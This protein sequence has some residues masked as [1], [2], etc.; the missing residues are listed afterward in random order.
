[1]DKVATLLKENLV[2]MK[3]GQ[4]AKIAEYCADDVR[5]T[6]ECWQLMTLTLENMSAPMLEEDLF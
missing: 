6:R 2:F 1:M 5:I 3:Q 4:I